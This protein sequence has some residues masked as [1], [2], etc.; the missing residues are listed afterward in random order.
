MLFIIRFIILPSI[1]AFDSNKTDNNKTG[2]SILS[3]SDNKNSAAKDSKDFRKKYLNH[4]NKGNRSRKFAA[5]A[6]RD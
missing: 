2:R 4:N 5:I 3:Y 1:L 6:W